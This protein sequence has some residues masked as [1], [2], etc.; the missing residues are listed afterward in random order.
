MGEYET[1]C[2]D[3]DRARE[4]IKNLH[5]IIGELEQRNKN[6]ESKIKAMYRDIEIMGEEKIQMDKK[7]DCLEKM[8]HTN[9]EKLLHLEKV[10]NQL[11]ESLD[12]ARY[13]GIG[14]MAPD[15]IPF[16]VKLMN[17]YIEQT[18]IL[19][20]SQAE[21]LEEEKVKNVLEAQLQELKECSCTISDVPIK[22]QHTIRARVKKAKDL[23]H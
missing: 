22:L 16:A 18:D 3:L 17:Q 21:I 20:Q 10:N 23:K 13:F 4:E 9:N 7:I 2:E 8:N 19:K 1:V 5:N 14:G 6:Q 15:N 12:R 11:E